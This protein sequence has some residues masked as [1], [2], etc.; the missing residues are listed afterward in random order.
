MNIYNPNHYEPLTPQ[1][2]PFD[3]YSPVSVNNSKNVNQLISSSPS[4]MIV[5]TPQTPSSY[6]PKSLNSSAT[7]STLV[8]LLH[9]KRPLLL[10]ASP[11]PS[12]R[13]SEQPR[14]P[15]KQPRKAPQRKTDAK[16][17]SPMHEDNSIHVTI[18]R[19]VPAANAILF[20]LSQC[21]RS[22][23]PSY[24]FLSLAE[25]KVNVYWHVPPPKMYPRFPPRNDTILPPCWQPVNT[26]PPYPLVCRC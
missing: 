23:R 12:T 22:I 11:S 18:E 15:S 24:R 16:R 25:A 4:S 2:L 3:G 6:H 8:N 17:F 5:T 1:T 10:E 7:S 26:V 21:P 20:L 9:Q 19:S 14:K 13:A